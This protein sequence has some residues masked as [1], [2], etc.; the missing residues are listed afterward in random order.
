MKIEEDKRSEF[1]Q[2]A[3]QIEGEVHTD[4][5]RRW[6]LSTDASI[7]QVMPVAVVYPKT[8][9]DV[10]ATVRFAGRHGLQVHPR[11]AG[12]GLCGS[13]LGNGIVVDFSKYMNRLLQLDVKEGW[14][15]C[16]PG[17]R[18]GELEAALTGSGLFFP[19]DPSSGEY[20][21]F[22]GM[23]NTN[24]SGAHSVKYGNVADYFLDAEVVFSN[25]STAV[26]SQ[27]E[28][29]D[30]KAL[31]PNLQSLADLYQDNVDDI[32]A[33]YPPIACNVAGYNLRNLVDRGRLRLHRLLAGAEGTLAVLTRLRFRLI[34]KP[35][36]DSLVVAYFDNIVNA[37]KA[38]QLTMPLSPSGIE[39][40][41]KSLLNLARTSDAALKERIPGDVDNV[42]LIEFDGSSSGECVRLAQK[43]QQQL[44]R[45]GL[46]NNIYAASTSEEKARF[47]AV[48][49]AAV[50]I[51]YKLKGSKKI[52]AL[53]ED[54]AVPVDRLV[55]YFKGIYE[56]FERHGVD[57]VLYG[58][59]A[60]GLMHTRPLLDL[61]DSGDVALLKIIADEVYDL[62]DGL[63]G[64]VSGEHGD[65]RLR[66]AY[67]Q[68]KYPGVYALFKKTKNLLDPPGMFN[69]EIKKADDPDQM[70]RHLRYG[71]RYRAK[72]LQN[73]ALLWPET[74]K[75]EA[76]K[77]HGCS[78]CTT[79]TAATRMCPIYKFTR[80]ETAAPKAKANILRS[81]ISG[82]I[83]EQALYEAGIINVMEQCVNCGS[84]H[85]ECP[86][87]VNIPKLVME[88]KAHYSDRTGLS[89]AQKLTANVE[90]AAR[91]THRFSPLTASV[92]RKPFARK[93]AS[94]LTGLADQR[95]MVVFSRRSLFQ[96]FP[97]EI[98]GDGPSVLY[99]AGCYAGYIRPELGNT[100]IHVM[101]RMGF[102]IQLPRQYCCG[103]PQL[104]K[105]LVA[106]ARRKVDHNL[107]AWLSVLSRIDHIVVTCSS[108]GFALIKD[109]GYM[110]QNRRLAERISEKTIHI[111][112]LLNHYS[113]RLKT[114]DLPMKLAYHHPCHLR[115]QPDS[116]SS[117]QLLSVL[118]GVKLHDLKSHCC[119]MAGSWGMIEKNYGLSKTIGTPMVE[120]LNASGA[121]YGVT[122]CPTC[123][124][125]MEHLGALPI[126]HPIEIVSRFII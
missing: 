75:D 50:P 9:G 82:K 114:R 2:L 41:D 117:K 21:T 52:L 122:D 3:A 7:F 101:S 64:T 92:M 73:L 108:C 91:M 86:S 51:L 79:V 69:P 49:K 67:L 32:E 23:C 65:G 53:V 45:N 1:S 66:S 85:V 76:E 27:L 38:V 100:A 111:S 96:Q 47:W 55:P 46:T 106:G 14:F 102:N 61:K 68:R 113:R 58:H 124:M 11:G 107:K 120:K 48:R 62:V 15:E 8:T 80:D 42:L 28:T 33:A 30:I 112:K 56:I 13:A 40:M 12:S 22:G 88:A 115:I 39:I 109:W 60:K 17:F 83:K 98:P 36:A 89:L 44:E 34:E 57:F 5:F 103:L 94:R 37:A 20:A 125:Q 25:G 35:A 126:R 84:C 81:L 97:K 74:F 43:A 54:A 118:P 4:T 105:G 90:L 71:A 31:P 26:L 59:I 116:D 119:G 70:K 10:Q 87:N 29:A 95:E 24:A 121:R 99:Y 6:M 78:K 110:I 104:S 18:L 63:D 77:C 123:Q 93:L 16:Q 72:E 19:P